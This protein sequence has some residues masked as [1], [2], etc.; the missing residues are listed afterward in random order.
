MASA[1]QF[2]ATKI[3]SRA[4]ERPAQRLFSAAASAVVKEEPRMLLPR[5][6]HGGSSLR[7]FSSSEAP[8][9]L[10]NNTK[11]FTQFPCLVQFA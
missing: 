7:R 5:I 2:V 11:V 4:L 8:N 10:N 6:R 3:C 9:L 1:L